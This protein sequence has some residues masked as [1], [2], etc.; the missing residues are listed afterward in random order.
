[1]ESVPSAEESPMQPTENSQT[2]TTAENSFTSL[3]ITDPSYVPFVTS[4]SEIQTWRACQRK[5]HY[6]FG[7]KL[8]SKNKSVPLQIGTIGHALLEVYFKERDEL[9]VKNAIHSTKEFFSKEMLENPHDYSSN[10]LITSYEAAMSFILDDPFKD[11]KILEVE[12]LYVTP[13]SSS[14]DL[15]M[16]VDLILESPEGRCV[17]VDHKFVGRPWDTP[18]LMMATQLDVYAGMLGHNGMVIN[19][20]MYN[21][22]YHKTKT[23][24]QE[25]FTYNPAKVNNVLR[26]TDMIAHLIARRLTNNSI[27]TQSQLSLRSH[28]QS[29]CGWCP[30]L[31]LCYGELTDDPKIVE[32]ALGN[33]GPNEYGYRED[34]NGN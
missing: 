24:A 32:A 2:A 15:A 21:F 1:M 30:F 16:R 20:K 3:S 28:E 6:A 9:G 11:Y 31:D 19:D 22:V 27:E 14:I 33:L 25:S 10:A 29:I 26:E 34:T 8:S 7:R 17:L 12:K 18:K 4:Y 5:H 23:H 13:I